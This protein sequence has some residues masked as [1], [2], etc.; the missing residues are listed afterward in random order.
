[1][2][3]EGCEEIRDA[4]RYGM[5]D[6][7]CGVRGAEFEERGVKKEHHINIDGFSMF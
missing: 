1:M 2:K 3:D 6:E 7:R 4:R 5:R